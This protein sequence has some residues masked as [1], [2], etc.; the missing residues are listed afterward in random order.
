MY[1]AELVADLV[2]YPIEKNQHRINRLHNYAYKEKRDTKRSR[3][4]LVYIENLYLISTIQ[5]RTLPAAL[6]G[7]VV[8][9]LYLLCR[10]DVAFS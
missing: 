3:T 2:H 5:T 7:M 9:V 4:H 1:L 6:R 8:K 10:G